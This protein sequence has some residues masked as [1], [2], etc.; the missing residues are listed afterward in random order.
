MFIDLKFFPPFCP[1][2]FGLDLDGS[3]LWALP[4]TLT[5][6]KSYNDLLF[7]FKE[8]RGQIQ[9]AFIPRNG[10]AKMTSTV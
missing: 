7:V 10:I 6:K 4:E 5:G 9:F 3:Q 8:L 1:N 2:P